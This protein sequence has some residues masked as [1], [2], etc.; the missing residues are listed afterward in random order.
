[1]LATLVGIQ[2]TCLT[3]IYRRG[4]KHFV[5]DLLLLWML[6]FVYCA[7]WNKVQTSEDAYQAECGR[8]GCEYASCDGVNK[9]ISLLVSILFL[10]APHA[11]MHLALFCDISMG[12]WAMELLEEEAERTRHDLEDGHSKTKGEEAAGSASTTLSHRKL[13][14]QCVKQTSRMSCQPLNLELAPCSGR[15]RPCDANFFFLITSKN[16]FSW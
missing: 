2:W 15:R 11:V 16:H 9:G 4:E 6:G 10:D 7:L 12:P 14:H 1:M 5:W 8:G 3:V 13:E